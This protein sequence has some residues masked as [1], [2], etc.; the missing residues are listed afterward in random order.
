MFAEII[1]EVIF[2]LIAEA[3]TIPFRL[4][5]RLSHPPNQGAE[6]LG[7]SVDPLSLTNCQETC[8]PIS[9]NQGEATSL[10]DRELDG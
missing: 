10:W 5:W 6:Q 7:T 8:S 4:A 3:I 1:F 9:Q 2:E